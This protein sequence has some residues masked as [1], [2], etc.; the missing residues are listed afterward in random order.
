MVSDRLSL[1]ICKVEASTK[2]ALV[3]YSRVTIRKR[4]MNFLEHKMR[5]ELL[6][7]PGYNECSRENAINLLNRFVCMDSITAIKMNS[8]K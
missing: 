7:L 8:K 5:L 3:R 6:T 4:Q 1:N 2:I